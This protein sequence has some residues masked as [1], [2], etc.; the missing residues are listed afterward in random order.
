MPQEIASTIFT[1]LWSL[2]END[3]RHISARYDRF[4]KFP[5]EAYDTQRFREQ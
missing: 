1:V 4:A 3:D 5:W 2:A